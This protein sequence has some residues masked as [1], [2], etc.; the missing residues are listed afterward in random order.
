MKL[1]ITN[2]KNQTLDLLGNSDK[3]ILYKAEALHGIDT[4]IQE[5]ESPYMDGSIVE[6]VKAL[7]REIE[8]GFKITGEV[9]DSI[10][11]FTN[12][13]KS[14]QQVTLTMIESEKEI[15]IKG[16]ATIPPYSRMSA[17]CEITLTIYCAQPYWEDLKQ[18]AGEIAIAIN[19]LNFP[20]QGQYFTNTGRPFGA[21]DTSLEKEFTNDG[22]TAVGM[23]IT[24][25]A[26]GTLENPRISCTSGEQEGWYM[27]LAVTLDDGD[28]VEI[29][30]TKG[31]KYIT[32]NGQDE[33]KGAPVLSYLN[34]VGNDWLQLEIGNNEFKVGA[35]SG[36]ESAYFTINYKRK[37]E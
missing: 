18:V 6:S 3:F 10:D 7:P 20:I 34:F 9:K 25:I 12:Y 24:I 36:K 5:S 13:I 26:L 21:L 31:N 33:Y 16:I 29:N 15:T 11:Y 4:D 22:D 35:S 14:K 32:I 23:N 37:Y 8:L 30:T 19:L 28:E 1:T 2:K 27:E 17:S